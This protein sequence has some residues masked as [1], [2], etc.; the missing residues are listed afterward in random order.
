MFCRNCLQFNRQFCSALPIQYTPYTRLG[1]RIRWRVGRT[2]SSTLVLGCADTNERQSSTDFPSTTREPAAQK[3]KLTE[4]LA[5][6]RLP[7]L[8]T[9][10]LQ[11]DEDACTVDEIN[12]VGAHRDARRIFSGGHRRRKGSVVGGHHGE[13]GARAYN[14]FWG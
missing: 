9:Q 7:T 10:E 8:P 3:R 5:E 13:C 6:S 4:T 12:C 1:E 14:G 11:E 2:N